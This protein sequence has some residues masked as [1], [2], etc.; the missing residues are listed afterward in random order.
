MTSPVHPDPGA[1][2]DRCR[3]AVALREKDLGIWQEWTWATYWEH[4]ELAGHALLA[5]GVEPGDRVAIHSENRPEW[6]VADM[7]ALAVR[8][9]SVGIYPTNPAAEVGYLLGDSGARILV[10]ED[11]EQVD[12]ALAVLDE[13]PDLERIVYLEPRGIRHRYDHE[14]LLSWE[15]VPRARPRAPRAAPRR[16]RRSARRQRPDDLATLIYTSGTTGPPKG[17]MLTRR[18]TSSSRSEVLVEE[19]AFTDPPPGPRDLSLSYLPL[20]HVAERI[21]TTWF[22]AA[23]GTQVNFAESIETVPQNLREVQ[24]TI[25]FGVPR[26]WEKLL[27]GHRDPALRRDLAQAQGRGVLARCRRPDRRRAWW[28]TAATHTAGTRLLY[29]RRLG[30][31]LPRAQ[32][33]AR[34]ARGPLRRLGCGADRARGAAVLHGHRRADARGLRHDRE[35]RGRHRQP[36]GPGQ[37]RHGRRGAPRHRAA[38]RRRRPARSSPGT[39]ACSSATGART[40]RPG[41]R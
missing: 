28:R 3:D 8:A 10:A 30:V 9:A 12:K 37:A 22:N 15:D 41:G 6:L 27:A 40:R 26:I 16:G 17:A 19:G 5:L 4:I 25:L 23:A 14:K 11:Q 24:P 34:H 38:D 13:C 39:P 36:A 20:S 33:P 7:G 35:H 31:L 1:R 32:G 21:F 29:A 18:P 2:R